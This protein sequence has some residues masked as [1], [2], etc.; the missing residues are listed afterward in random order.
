MNITWYG[1]SCFLIKDSKGRKLLTDPFDD[2]VGYECPNDSV[3]VITISHHHFDHDCTE[4]LPGSPVVLDKCG[5][6]NLCDIPISGLPSYHDK[7]MGAKRGDNVIFVFQMDE[8][9]LC[10]LGDLGHLLYSEDL[11]R[12]GKVDILFIPVG[13]NFTIDGAE[14]AQVA[15]A[16]DASIVIPMHY[17]TPALSFPLNGVEDFITK[18]KNGDKIPNPTL[19][20]DCLPKAHNNVKVLSYKES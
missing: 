2:S 1:H 13:G 9:R 11:D 20:I 16:I 3:D 10:H 12:I 6:F 8:F 14:A 5:F 4:K 15:K 19:S 17:K 18:M 7:D